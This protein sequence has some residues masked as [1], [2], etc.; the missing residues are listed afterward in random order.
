MVARDSSGAG[1]DWHAAEHRGF[2][3]SDVIAN[4]FL[5]AYFGINSSHILMNLDGAELC[6][7][8]MAKSLVIFES[9]TQIYAMNIKISLQLQKTPIV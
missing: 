7:L 8:F 6:V 4:F 5:R 2:I 3:P 1:L 9:C